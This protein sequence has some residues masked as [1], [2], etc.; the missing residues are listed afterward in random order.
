[1]LPVPRYVVARGRDQAARAERPQST[2]S[3]D[4]GCMAA[5]SVRALR[6]AP[7]M[8]LFGMAAVQTRPSASEDWLLSY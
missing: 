8:G 2:A 5:R 6:K 7:E 4:A 1:M 3:V